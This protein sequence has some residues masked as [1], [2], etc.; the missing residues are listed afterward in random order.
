VQLQA[1][2]HGGET[3]N[4]W[5][6]ADRSEDRYAR[7]IVSSD[8]SVSV[9]IDKPSTA[10]KIGNFSSISTGLELLGVSGSALDRFDQASAVVV[11]QTSTVELDPVIHG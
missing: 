8:R 7:V 2:V 1:D 11:A 4:G 9:S 6:G 10:Q 5:S 3:F